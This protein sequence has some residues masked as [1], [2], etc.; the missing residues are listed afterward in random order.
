MVVFLHENIEIQGT[1]QKV[2]VLVPNHH[3]D[4]NLLPVVMVLHGGAFMLGSKQSTRESCQ[5]LAERGLVCVA[6]DYT[7]SSL[8]PSQS[9][10]LCNV[11]MVFLL[12]LTLCCN[13]MLQMTFVLVMLLA[14]LTGFLVWWSYDQPAVQHPAHA[15]DVARALKWTVDHIAE[16]GG[17]PQSIHLLGH[18]AGGHLAALLA[19]NSAY[20]TMVGV[21]EGTIRSCVSVSGLYSDKRLQE[22][23]AGRQILHAAFGDK[24]HYYDAF[25]IYHVRPGMS[26][27]FL[28]MNAGLDISTKRH[29]FDFHYA[30]RQ[31]GAYVET[32]YFDHLN[33]FNIMDRWNT[34]HV[35]VLDTIERHIRDA[36]AVK[37]TLD[38]SDARPLEP[39]PPSVPARAGT[40][41]GTPDRPGLSS[42][43]G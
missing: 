26:T 34:D 36:D 23:A 1:S 27:A 14:V 2:D 7:L 37:I 22:T 17:D 19:T 4:R 39:R 32:V 41:E 16:Y 43:S 12:L 8:S 25:P 33:H 30:L 11:A 10:G 9:Y 24:K 15:L 35:A 21:P 29:T 42:P 3:P 38:R 20:T 13:S 40:G 6:A 5:A 28:L 18:S 31:A